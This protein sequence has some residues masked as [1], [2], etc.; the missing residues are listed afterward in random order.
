MPKKTKISILI[1][2]Y[3]RDYI[4]KECL[5]SI[6]EQTAD[7]SLY[8][9]IVINN[10]STDRTLEIAEYYSNNYKNFKVIT[11]PRQ[12][13]SVAR[14]RGYKE[15]KYDWVSYIDD[16]AKAFPDYVERALDT[17]EKHAFDCFGGMYYPWYRNSQRPKWLSENFGQSR[18]YNEDV[19][20]LTN[21]YITGGV[22]VFRKAPLDIIGGFPED[23]GMTGN[24]I[25]YGEEVYVQNQLVAKGYK[26]GFDAEL[27]IEH[28][29]PEYKLTLKWH[30]QSAYAHGRDAVKI[31]NEKERIS[32]MQFILTNIKIFAK[33]FLKGIKAL[34]LQRNYYWQNLI[35]EIVKPIA[36]YKG[37]Y[38]ANRKLGDYKN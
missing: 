35:L 11:E 20:L 27:C 7:K 24:K 36:R 15:A 12:G 33:S 34:L 31:F 3:N 1:C 28:L 22:C 26:A 29:V 19:A 9:V 32:T 21:G 18:K 8:E 38:F 10:N 13:L 25:A 6:V 16:D 4:L 30:I 17:I 2:T 23:L 37:F 14:N 5:A